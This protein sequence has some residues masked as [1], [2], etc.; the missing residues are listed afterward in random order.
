MTRIYAAFGRGLYSFFLQIPNSLQFLIKRL[1]Y[2]P[3]MQQS[4]NSECTSCAAEKVAAATTTREPQIGSVHSWP[5]S[6]LWAIETSDKSGDTLYVWQRKEEGIRRV[7]R[8]LSRA[9]TRGILTNLWGISFLQLRN[10]IRTCRW[11]QTYRSSLRPQ[12]E[13]MRKMDPM[14][15]VLPF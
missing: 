15:A 1:W 14:N 12:V 11:P 7:K 4:A 6:N 5:R 10:T 9:E 13:A 3:L 2:W 8:R